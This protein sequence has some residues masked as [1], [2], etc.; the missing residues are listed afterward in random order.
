M[1]VGGIRRIRVIARNVTRRS[2]SEGGALQALYDSTYAGDFRMKGGDAGFLRIV[3]QIGPGPA[4]RTGHQHVPPPSK[5]KAGRRVAAV[6]CKI[7]ARG[8]YRAEPSAEAAFKTP[9]MDESKSRSPV[10]SG[11]IR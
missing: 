9:D 2:F 3:R 1:F 11:V 4:K 10:S 5:F 6:G 7:L 8:A